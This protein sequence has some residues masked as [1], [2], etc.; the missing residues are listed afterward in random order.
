VTTS[1]V[2]RFTW[3][4]SSDAGAGMGHYAVALQTSD[5]PPAM[6]SEGQATVTSAQWTPATPASSGV[7]Y[8]YIRAD[9]AL[10]NKS[11]WVRMFVYVYGTIPA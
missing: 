7:Y 4:A 8:L 5:S 11:L 2:P 10:E 9:D 3:T 1:F 6:S